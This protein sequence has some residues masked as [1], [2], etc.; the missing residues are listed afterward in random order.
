[1]IVSVSAFSQKQNSKVKEVEFEVHGTCHM[2]KERIE[3][4]ALIKGVKYAE[5]DVETHVLKVVYKSNSTTEE[6]IHNSIAKAGHDTHRV[7]A[8]DEDYAKLNSCCKYRDADATGHKC[9]H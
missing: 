9:N 6:T 5:W 4:A 2:C 1:M 7:K 8:T 3:N